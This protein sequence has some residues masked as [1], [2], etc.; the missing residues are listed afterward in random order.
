MKELKDFT[1]FTRVNKEFKEQIV[2]YCNYT[3]TTVSQLIYRLLREE[4]ARNPI[5]GGKEDETSR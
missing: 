3:G 2:K 4:M 1:L 5:S